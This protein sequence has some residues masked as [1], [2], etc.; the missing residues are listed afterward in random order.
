[1][2]QQKFSLFS[3][4]Y[5]RT[6]PFL[7]LHVALIA[8]VP[9]TLVLCMMG[10]A[11]GDP[12]LPGWLEMLLLGLPPV[13]LVVWLQ[14]QKP[15]S[16]FSIWVLARPADKLSVNQRR[17]LTLLKGQTSNTKINPTGWIAVVAGLFLYVVFRQMYISAPLA[18]DIAPFPPVLRLFGI[19]WALAFFA[20]SNLL[21]QAGLAAVRILL[22]S[23][24]D[25]ESLSPYPVE[26]IKASF[27]VLGQR[28]PK[29]FAYASETATDSLPQSVTLST[30]T[31]AIPETTT[32]TS[33]PSATPASSS[34]GDVFAVIK[35]KV[36]QV[37]EVVV[38]KLSNLVANKTSQR[39]SAATKSSARKN[40]ASEA[41]APVELI[42][43]FSEQLNKSVIPDVKISAEEEQEFL[44]DIDTSPASSEVE[45]TASVEESSQSDSLPIEAIAEASAEISEH[46]EQSQS[47]ESAELGE[48]DSEER[49]PESSA[50]AA[51]NDNPEEHS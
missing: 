49:S 51:S 41:E 4:T 45:N 36:T 1:M 3:P 21:W 11:V 16:P 22:M 30:P 10:L 47:A 26:Q 19:G 34:A 20:V 50:E 5:Q 8:A 7:W 40:K 46:E 12:V 28:S 18:A 33:A 42:A 39:P 14:W 2:T 9:L 44:S 29:L 24:A 37:S 13:A 23:R 35:S 25:F 15:L 48:Q 43:E 27:T 6:E 32:Q 31:T 38:G 17:V